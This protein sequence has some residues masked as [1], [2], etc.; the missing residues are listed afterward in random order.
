MD[1]LCGGNHALLL[2]LLK[3]HDHGDWGNC[4][5][6]DAIQNNWATHNEQRIM[7]VYA[8][9]GAAVWIITERDRSATTILLLTEY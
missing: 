1:E 2:P 6:E 7:S 4:Y 8:F 3:R 9:L 5:Q